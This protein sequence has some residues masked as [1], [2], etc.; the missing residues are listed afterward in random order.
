VLKVQTIRT[1]VGVIVGSEH[2]RCWSRA[3]VYNKIS[4]DKDMKYGC[5]GGDNG[6]YFL[7]L[8]FFSK[9]NLAWLFDGTKETLDGVCLVGTWKM[10][11]AFCSSINV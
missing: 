7:E 6:K 4:V 2:P 5:R 11:G 9:F 3:F 8:F 1:F 10:F